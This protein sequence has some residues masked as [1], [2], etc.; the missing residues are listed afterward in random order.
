MKIKSI[1]IHRQIKSQDL[2]HHGTLFAGRAAE[3]FVEAGLIAAAS[4]T[5][6]RNVV[7]VNIHGMVFSKPVHVEKILKFESKVVFTGRTRIVTNVKIVFAHNDELVLSG[8]LTFVHVNEK[9]MPVPH[10]IVI[11]PAGPE[12]LELQRLAESLK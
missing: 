7:C 8:F 6:P 4:L 2:N 12:D 10:G 9:G 5:S 3:W 11:E 1:I